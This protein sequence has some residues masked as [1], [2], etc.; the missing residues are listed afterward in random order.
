MKR[1]FLEGLGLEKE[2]VDK[3]MAEN[4]ADIEREKAKT[5]QAKADLADA[6]EQLSARDKD[7]EELRKSASGADD[8]Q[9]QLAELQ[10]KYNTETEQYK[11]QIAAR[12]YSDAI[13]RT[14]SGKGL[15]FTSKSAESAFI[16]LLK[17][18]KLEL[19]DGELS[20]VD[21]IID[22]QRKADPDA[23]ASDKP[24]PRFMGPSGVGGTPQPPVSRVAQISAEYHNRLYGET[25]KE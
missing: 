7:L 22:E 10:E 19:K 14:I 4:G 18:K 12:D 1:E 13:S 21:A 17:E 23:F 3:I 8:V 15:K 24:K 11:A 6:Q 2:A 5:T 20:G 9:K 25:K 16:S